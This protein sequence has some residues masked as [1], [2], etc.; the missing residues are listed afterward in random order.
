[1]QWHEHHL[2]CY[3]CG[4]KRH[5]ANDEY[6]P[7]KDATCSAC[8][9]R[10]HFAR[11]CMSSKRKRSYEGNE[12]DSYKRRKIEVRQMKEERDVAVNAS[13]SRLD[14]LS[15]NDGGI[16]VVCAIGNV[17]VEMMIDSGT[18]RNIIDGNTWDLMVANGFKPR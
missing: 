4:S 12:R 10:G 2:Q 16:K 15:V 9:K 14:I 5:K 13:T 17:F 1:M 3:R 18:S 6:C 7:A 11:K 8:G